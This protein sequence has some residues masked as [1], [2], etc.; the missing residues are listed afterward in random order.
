MNL[1]SDA[2]N[3]TAIQAVTE[4]KARLNHKCALMLLNQDPEAS[5]K[6]MLSWKVSSTNANNIE[7]IFTLS[8]E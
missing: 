1:S 4:G 6:W 7:L 3:P 2:D 8:K 5:M